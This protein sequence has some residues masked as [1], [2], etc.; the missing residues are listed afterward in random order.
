M[1]YIVKTLFVLG[2]LTLTSAVEAQQSEADVAQLHRMA[3]R[4]NADAQFTLGGMY[5]SGRGVSQDFGVSFAWYRRAAEQGHVLAQS[6]LGFMYESGLGVTPD[7]RMAATWFR[8][9]AEQGDV[10]AR[11]SLNRLLEAQNATQQERRREAERRREDARRAEADCAFPTYPEP[12][13]NMREIGFPWCPAFVDFSGGRVHALTAE[14][15]WCG[16]RAGEDRETMF[17]LLRQ[18]CSYLDAMNAT[19]R[20]DTGCDCADAPWAETV[21]LR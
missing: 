1:R 20:G 13:S 2:V 14:A 3:E 6:T 15:R 8:R 21:G 4:G 7:L 5:G 12:P 10:I 16:Y 9:A 11:D 19:V 17:T 18:S